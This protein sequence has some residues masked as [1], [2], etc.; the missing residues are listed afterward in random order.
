MHNSTEQ[1]SWGE[2]HLYT[3]SISTV[4][5]SIEQ[6]GG[7]SSVPPRQQVQY[8]TEQQGGTT[9]VN[10]VYKYSSVQ[11][12]GTTSVPPCLQVQYNTVQ[13]GGTTSVHPFISTVQYSRK[14]LPLYTLYT[15]KAP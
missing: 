14:E 12:G 8:S 3:L 7:T 13:Q 2:L 5:Y 1:N 10:P 15:S 9:S 11:Q 6:H 4:H